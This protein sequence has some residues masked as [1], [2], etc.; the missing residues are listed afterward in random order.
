MAGHPQRVQEGR[1][2]C[3][4]GLT[5]CSGSGGGHAVCLWGQPEVVCFVEVHPVT[6]ATEAVGG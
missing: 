5:A 3:T 2:Q 4:E 6:M 1:H